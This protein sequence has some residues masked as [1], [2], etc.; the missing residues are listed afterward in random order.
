MRHTS[1]ATDHLYQIWKESILNCR[2]QR[3]RRKLTKN[4]KSKEDKVKVTNL[5]NSPKF[6]IFEFWNGHYTWH[7]FWS[8]LIR[9]ANMK[10]IQWVL[11]KIQSG[12]DSVHRR[13]DGQTDKVILVY[14]PFN[15]VEAGGIMKQTHG[16]SAQ[17]LIMWIGFNKWRHLHCILWMMNNTNS[18]V[19]QIDYTQTQLHTSAADVTLT[20]K[21][22]SDIVKDCVNSSPLDKMAAILQTIFSDAFSRRKSFGFWSKFHWSLLLR[23]Q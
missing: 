13:T 11:L 5:K 15:F 23:V 18:L 17:K 8:C 6:Q 21:S 4:N 3:Q 20:Y 1:H 2:R 9:C 16:F 10:W 22:T 19:N 12:H 7:T 14:P